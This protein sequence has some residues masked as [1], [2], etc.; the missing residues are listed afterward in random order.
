MDKDASRITHHASL[1]LKAPAKI[2]WFLH[3]LGLRDDG[4]HEIHSLMQKIALYDVLTFSPSDD[5]TV[6]TEAPIPM[7]QN[8]V[9]KAAMLL[10]GA[11]GVK[12][13]ARIILQ[14]D[15]PAGAGLGGGSSDAAAT[16]AGL[17]ELWSVKF[18]REKLC[19]LAAQLGSDVPFFL[20]GA[21]SVAQGRGEKLTPFRSRK[22]VPILLIKPP[23]PVSTAWAYGEMKRTGWYTERL[24]L[25]NKAGKDN[26][27]EFLI[28][29]I[30]R[31]GFGEAAGIIANDLESVTVKS[32]PVIA[33]I[34]K[35]L[36][37]EGAV[38]SLMSGSGPTVFGVFHSLGDAGKASKA[39]KGC[40]TAVVNTITD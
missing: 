16:L 32:F 21:L 40:W 30:E 33:D 14:K 19:A 22:T 4:Y 18:P 15:I 37:E 12:G 8:L 23:F 31:T 27:I 10:R 2:N 29:S 35:K 25:T 1:S 11:S 20:H 39:F 28:S 6:E 9:Y 34:K 7:E 3:V 5:L 17:N 38:I 13:G 26:N 36:I 24:K